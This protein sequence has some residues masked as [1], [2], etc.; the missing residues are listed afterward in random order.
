MRADRRIKNHTLIDCVKKRKKCTRY[1]NGHGCYSH[2]GPSNKNGS[3]CWCLWRIITLNNQF[4]NDTL[5]RLTL[6]TITYCSESNETCRHIILKM[7]DNKATG[8][9]L[10][11]Y[12]ALP[13]SHFSVTINTTEPAYKKIVRDD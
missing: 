7:I 5:K 4:S 2:R 12:T 11:K 9:C 13:N 3:T 1:K 10:Q 8:K 6:P